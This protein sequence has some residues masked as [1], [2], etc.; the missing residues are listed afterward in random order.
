MECRQCGAKLP[1][2]A[3][4][5]PLCGTAVRGEA[6]EASAQDCA[7]VQEGN[8]EQAAAESAK[9]PQ[10]LQFGPVVFD[11]IEAVVG[12]IFIVAG[13]S[14]FAASGISVDSASFGADFYTYTYG[15]IQ[16]AVR[17]LGILARILSVLM[18]LTGILIACCAIGRMFDRRK[19]GV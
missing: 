13:L 17:L 12:A 18:V 14:F 15:G 19:G 1:S 10:S 9:K 5:C 3:D 7:A 4:F 2:E 8:L 6:A 16:A 11:G